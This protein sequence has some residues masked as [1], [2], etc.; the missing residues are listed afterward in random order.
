M[1]QIAALLSNELEGV[2]AYGGRVVDLN[3]WIL[4]AWTASLAFLEWLR[5]LHFEY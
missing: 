4:L 1:D 3:G 2:K 5:L